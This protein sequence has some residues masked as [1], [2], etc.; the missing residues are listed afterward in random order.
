MASPKQKTLRV[1]PGLKAFLARV[2][3][4][5]EAGD[6]EPLP[7]TFQS[8]TTFGGPSEGRDG[9]FEFTHF[10]ESGR[11]QFVLSPPQI[12]DI[13]R[14]AVGRVDVER[15]DLVPEAVDDDDDFL[16]QEEA[17]PAP[18]LASVLVAALSGNAP[19]KPPEDPGAY[20]FIDVLIKS[21]AIEL[22]E[23]AHPAQL[24]LGVKKILQT[25]EKA[26]HKAKALSEWLFE[27]DGVV[28][29]VYIDDAKL[30]KLIWSW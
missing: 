8:G 28:E 9:L 16:F 1:S 2:H 27:Q 3:V 25:E 19:T 29:E 18:D 21:G 11:C 23:G 15:D 4:L 12:A 10:A 20:K 26:K 14:G 6:Y 5:I 24:M 13:G 17:A 30:A 22:S 7:D